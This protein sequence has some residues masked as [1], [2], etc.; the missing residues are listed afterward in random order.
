[1]SKG[2]VAQSDGATYTVSQGA[3]EVTYDGSVIRD[4]KNGRLP[5]HGAG[6]VGVGPERHGYGHGYRDGHCHRD[7][8]AG[9]TAAG[10]GRRS[11]ANA[12]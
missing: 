8:N 12:G 2:F 7:G 6:L 11:A 4:E 10:R 5:R 9:Q 3:L 1:M